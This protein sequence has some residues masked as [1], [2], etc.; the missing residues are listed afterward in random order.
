MLRTVIFMLLSFVFGNFVFA[1]VYDPPSPRVY[2]G[3]GGD[4]YGS[5]RRPHPPLPPIKDMIG[6]SGRGAGCGG[7]PRPRE[8]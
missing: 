8:R 2:E 6:H 7:I 5:W 4:S 3:D 1:Q